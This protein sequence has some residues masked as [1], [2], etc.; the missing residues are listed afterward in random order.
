MVSLCARRKEKNEGRDGRMTKESTN[1]KTETKLFTKPFARSSTRRSFIVSLFSS[2]YIPFRETRSLARLSISLPRKLRYR[3]AAMTSGT[4]R[5][6]CICVISVYRCQKI[7][8]H[9]ISA[10]GDIT[11]SY[12]ISNNYTFNEKKN[13]E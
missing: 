2:K 11:P 5:N 8:C 7:K 9:S 12:L 10:A 4:K 1:S 13:I 6:L 3:N